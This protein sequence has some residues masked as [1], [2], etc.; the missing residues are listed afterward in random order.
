MEWESARQRDSTSI[1]VKYLDGRE[2]AQ[3]PISQSWAI[4]IGTALAFCFKTCL[5]VEAVGVAFCQGFWFSVRRNAVRLDGL[6]AMF[7]VLHNPLKF[8]NK[9][10][11]LRAKTLVFLGVICWLLPITAILSPGALTGTSLDLMADF[12]CNTS[13]DGVGAS[14]RPYPRLFGLEGGVCRDWYW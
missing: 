7:S 8:L 4:R 5:N 10:I 14:R 6:D 11:Y 1:T 12:S 9:D 2:V 3:A 13:V